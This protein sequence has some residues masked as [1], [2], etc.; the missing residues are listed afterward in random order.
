MRQ[1]TRRE[2]IKTG[3]AG[4][5][6]A[7]TPSCCRTSV[8]SRGLYHAD[9]RVYLGQT[10]VR[11]SRL[12]IGTGIKAG[13]YT[14]ALLR[15]GQKHFEDLM[16][17]YL[18]Q[19]LNFFEM[20]DWYG[21]HHYTRTSLK[22]VPRQNYV[23]STKIWTKDNANPP[24]SGGALVEVDRFRRELDTDYLDICLI[25]CQTRADWPY[26]QA[27]VRDELSELKSKGIVKAVGV[28]CHG[29]DSL[30]VAA[31][32]PWIDIIFARL[33][34][35]GG[36]KFK[37]DGPVGET[38]KILKRARV[39]GKAVVGM[40]IFAEGRLIQPKEKDASLLHVLHGGLVD[41]VTIGMQEQWE[42][43]DCVERVGKV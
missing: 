26:F 12:A 24:P 42:V 21:S 43:D 13:R 22:G 39:N 9:D 18:D 30:R 41:A 38:E 3:L 36:R 25:H 2:A 31:E 1:Y 11:A 28:S 32:D 15:K 4:V 17:H 14:S 19:G 33:N 20:A 5:G 35:K 7:V 6:L 16:H 10:G 34:N 27:R 23:L 37:M 40:K 29:Y 8:P